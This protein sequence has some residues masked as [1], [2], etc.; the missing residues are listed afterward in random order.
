MPPSHSVANPLSQAD[1]D[2]QEQE[3]VLQI[4]LATVRHFFG[5]FTQL[6]ASVID[7]RQPA[8]ITYPLAALL[9][10]GL[11]LFVYH[12][13]AR[14][15]I[16]HKLRG[17]QASA[18]KF[19]TLFGVAQ[20]PHGDTLEAAFSRLQPAELQEVVSGL[21]ETL[22]RRK[23]LTAT[24]LLDQY[25]LVAM[26]GT[27]VLVFPERHC[28][29]CLTRTQHGVTTY[30]HPLLEAK[31]VTATGFAFS[32]LT[33]FIE[34]PEET[35]TKQDCELRAFYR[36]AARLKHRFPRL[37]ICLLLDGLYAGG[38]TFTCCEQYGWKYLITLQDG[39]LPS[40]HRD[41]EALL[42]L[43]PE[44]HVRFTPSGYPP[45][46]QDFHWMNDLVYV[47]TQHHAHT[48][49]VID[50]HEAHS[51]DGQ[52]KNTQFRWVGNFQVTAHNVLALANQGGRLRWKIENEGFNVQKTKG[53][54]LEHAF[55]QN[56][57][58]AKVFYFLLQ[59]AHLLN[60]LMLHGSLFRHA[61]PKGV[62]SAQNL[63]W[64]LLEAWRNVR[65]PLVDLIT[66]TA[67]RFQIRFDSS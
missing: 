40:L 17:N 36:L 57:I 33:E 12:L 38:P 16:N 1:R 59:I 61:F 32:L 53:Y 48:L 52:V 13:G 8:L 49:A 62:G 3:A 56:P 55:T 15:Q 4:F 26:D 65:R 25:Y 44:N 46:P 5:S 58:A 34:N 31:L 24:R 23:V 2:V 39:D 50:C 21:T 9:T 10:A 20:C 64:R 14:R 29:H 7:P 60:Q 22:I 63:A 66:H 35:P 47:D 37:P 43:A 30:Y 18:A 41:F 27:G 11:F 19:E 54:A 67:D 45:T 28:A 6:F 51:V 42:P